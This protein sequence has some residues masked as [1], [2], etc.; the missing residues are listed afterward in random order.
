MAQMKDHDQV[1]HHLSHRLDQQPAAE[2]IAL[3][4]G[5]NRVDEGRAGGRKARVCENLF[6]GVNGAGDGWGRSGHR[7]VAFAASFAVPTIG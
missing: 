4:N 5:D 1:E 7:R 3:V 2:W 6:G